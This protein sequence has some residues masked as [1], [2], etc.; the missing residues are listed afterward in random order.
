MHASHPWRCRCAAPVQEPPALPYLADPG[1]HS[2][3]IHLEAALL[4]A[5][6]EEATVLTYSNFCYLCA[7][8]HPLQPTPAAQAHTA[9]ATGRPHMLPCFP[10]GEGPPDLP[11]HAGAAMHAC[12]DLLQA[13]TLR[14]C[15]HAGTGRCRRWWR[16]TPSAA[17]ICAQG[18]CWARAPSRTSA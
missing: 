13:E 12:A 1:R 2:Y 4:P 7:R 16:T 17:A 9:T 3:D 8:C 14:L 15:V 10:A 5:E 11:V 18:T 6:L